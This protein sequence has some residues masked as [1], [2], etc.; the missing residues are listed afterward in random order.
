MKE[1]WKDIKGYEGLYQVSNMGRVKSLKRI[2]LDGRR[3]EEKILKYKRAGRGQ[4]QCVRL[5]KN[6]TSKYK[7]IHRLV[8]E[9][10]VPNPNNLPQV[11]HKDENSKN[12]IY[13]NLEW[14]TGKYNV[15]YGTR[16]LRM[17]EKTNYK[18]LTEKLKK[19]VLKYDLNYN[20][21]DF[22]ESMT[23]AAKKNNVSIGNISSCCNKKYKSVGNYIYRF[24]GD[25]DFSNIINY[26]NKNKKIISQYS[27][28]GNFIKQY[29]S[30]LDAA[31]QNNYKSPSS[32][33]NCCLGNNKTA[34]GYKWRYNNSPKKIFITSDEHGN[35]EAMKKAEEEAG[36]DETNPNHFRISLG[37]CFDREHDS[38]KIYEYYKRLCD[39]GK[40]I[41]TSSNHFP[42]F[43]HFLEGSYNPFNYLHNGLSETVAD[44]WHRTAPFESWCLLEG[45]CDMTQENYAK[46]V[47]ICRKDINE[48]YP[49]LL[50]WLK[51]LPRYFETKN[52]IMVHGAID[53]KVSD[54]H[55]PHCYRGNLIDWDALD[56]NDG[57]FFGEQIINTDK[58]VI[59]GHF[60]TKQL[61]EMYPNLTTKDDKEPYDILIRD[62]DKI[63]AIDSTVVLSKKINVLVLED[64][65]IIDNI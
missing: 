53:T 63:I 30:P 35:Y 15:N 48:E 32:I 11:N 34:Y 37:D 27:L 59:I 50:P 42:F 3:I 54:W 47:D 61:R 6:N 9:A 22:Y 20:L 19:K 14:C 1:I 2:S 51:S 56:F 46:W 60:G 26:K 45:Q 55:N 64:E 25:N 24:D 8:A 33:Y 29:D 57:S 44:F 5:Y 10:F 36:Y 12:N 40:M 4:Y 28:N 31:I 65:E 52:Y 21:V 7:T 39:E 43:I 17:K 58:T 13:S 23:E 49:E 38:L 41:V 16:N 62:D 18:L